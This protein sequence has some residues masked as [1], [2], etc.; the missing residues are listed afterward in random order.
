MLKLAPNMT[1]HCALFCPTVLHPWRRSWRATWTRPWSSTT[2]SP[3]SSPAA[4]SS[5]A[6]APSGAW[7]TSPMWSS[8]SR[9]Q[10]W[11]TMLQPQPWP[12][13]PQVLPILPSPRFDHCLSLSLEYYCVTSIRWCTLAWPI[14]AMVPT[15]ARSQLSR[16]DLWTPTACF[17]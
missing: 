10:S 13:L 12:S 2:A 17:R 9:S 5:R 16:A 14:L 15:E 3:G 4:P 6:S 8:R 11:P 1:R 7:G